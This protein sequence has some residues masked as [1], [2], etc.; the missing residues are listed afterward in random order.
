MAATEELF[1]LGISTISTSNYLL[2]YRLSGL[3]KSNANKEDPSN[4]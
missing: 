1:P 4:H 2:L 3:L